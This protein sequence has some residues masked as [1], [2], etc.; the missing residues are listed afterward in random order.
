M[1][2]KEQIMIDG[3]DVSK[4][5]QHRKCILPDNIG[6]KIDDMLCCD[7][8]N[9]EYK[10]LQ[11]KNAEC[12][13]YE[14]ALNEIEEFIITDTCE[15][16]KELEEDNCDE[17]NGRIILDII[18]KAKEKEMKINDV[19][20]KYK[21]KEKAINKIKN[22]YERALHLI[23]FKLDNS[24]GIYQNCREKNRKFET[25]TKMNIYNFLKS[26]EFCDNDYC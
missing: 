9:C 21:D 17:C 23:L 3:V 24:F 25:C 5:K 12:E 11:R 13:K 8:P 4:C 20:K 15:P 22:P 19:C 26:K 6:C 14:Q 18:N 7:K 1:T 2:D 16:C 10:Q